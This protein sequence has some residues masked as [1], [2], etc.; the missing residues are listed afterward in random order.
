MCLCK[1]DNI[2]IVPQAGSVLGWIIIS[3]N[4]QALSLSDCSLSDEWN[5]VVRNTARK[6]TDKS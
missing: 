5:Q 3:E 2:D 4:A 1:I 6:L